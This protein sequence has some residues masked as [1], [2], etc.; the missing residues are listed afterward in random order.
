VLLY[1]INK[2]HQDHKQQFGF[3]TNSSCSHAVF[4]VTQAANFAEQNG[5]RLYTCAVDA[6]KAF[7]KVSRPHLWIKLMRLKI[8]TSVVIAII[9]Y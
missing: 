2:G 4:V 5:Q 3:K 7:D 1:E 6:S 9:V 8:Q